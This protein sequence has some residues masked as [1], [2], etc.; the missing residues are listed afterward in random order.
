MQPGQLQAR[1]FKDYPPAAR[2]LIVDHLDLVRQLPMVFVALLL[3]E[4]KGYDWR[5]PAERR[6]LD[7][8]FTFLQSLTPAQRDDLLRTFAEIELPHDVRSMDWVQHTQKFLDGLTK[9]LWATHQIDAFTAAATEYTAAWNKAEPEPAPEMPRLGIVV[10]G[11][12]L[13][14]DGYRLFRKLRPHG[15]FVPEVNGAGGWQEILSAVQARAAKQ[16]TAYRH[17]YIDGGAT[18]AAGSGL[19]TTSYEGMKL[20]REAVLNQIHEII[21]S[22]HGGP[23]QLRTAM[24]EITPRELKFGSNR[25]DEVMHH[26]EVDVQTEGSGTQ[27][28]STTFVMWSAREALR[29]AQP[30]TTLLRYAPRQRQLPMNEMLSSRSKQA[31]VDPQGSVMDA[32]IGAFY[33]WVDQQRL[34][35]AEASSFLAW[36]EEHKQAVMIS[37]TMPRGTVAGSSLTVRQMLMQIS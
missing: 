35:G 22:G 1:D 18:D 12:G 3:R 24:A 21:A 26:F 4:V 23:E 10:L 25:E 15:V 14:Y 36:S 11:A 7:A 9:T 28:F 27:I 19:A 16:P 33:A 34:T 30:Y 2:K 6:V 17:W 37:P 13:Q 31:G 20:V 5:F 29:R 8:Q 32:D